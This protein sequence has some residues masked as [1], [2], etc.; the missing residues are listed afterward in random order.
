MCS[1]QN[2]IDHATL[3]MI[4]FE[5]GDPERIQHFLKVHR[6]AQLIARNEQV[7][8]YTQFVTELAAVVH[9][10]GIHPAEAKY[11]NCNGKY[12]E[13][14]G[15]DCVRTLLTPLGVD[16]NDI[17]RV[18]YL[19]GHHHTYNNID[20]IDYQILV[21]ADFLVNL[22][23]DGVSEHAAD[24][25]LEKIFRTEMGKKLCRLQFKDKYQKP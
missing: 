18:C 13:E 10:I 17:E 8:E 19:V 23:E 14:L 11:G 6:F 15:P 12:Q 4:D 20:G 24:N 16:K 2:I 22:F 21:E 25:A 7:D 5:K 9:D 3:A 1:K